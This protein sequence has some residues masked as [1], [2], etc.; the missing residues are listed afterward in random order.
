MK[1]GQKKTFYFSR[2]AKKVLGYFPEVPKK[3]FFFFFGGGGKSGLCRGT[4]NKN[5]Y[6]LPKLVSAASAAGETP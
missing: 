4:V 2:S 5:N 3:F 6:G 1:M